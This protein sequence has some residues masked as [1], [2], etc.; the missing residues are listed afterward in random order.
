MVFKI[1]KMKFLIIILLVTTT[2]TRVAAQYDFDNQHVI[3]TNNANV[4]IGTNDPWTKLQL[5]GTLGLGKFS[6]SQHA[7]L[8]IDY[9]D[10]NGG[11]GTTT[12]K[13]Q[14]WGGGF[15]FRRNDAAGERNQFFF[16][17]ASSHYMDIYDNNNNVAVRFNSGGH[18]FFNGNVGIGT[19][20]PGDKLEISGRLRVST[21]TSD[22]GLSYHT[23]D[24]PE[25]GYNAVWPDQFERA[26]IFKS[27]AYMDGYGAGGGG[28][29]F[30]TYDKNDG[31]TWGSFSG[32][33]KQAMVIRRN[34]N[35]GVGTA[36]PDA[37]L[38]VKGDIHTRE[39]RVDMTGA[40]GPDYVFEKN[41]SLLPLSQLESY[42]NQNKHLPEVSSAKEMEENGLNLK[43]MNLILLKKVEE[44][45]LHLIEMKKANEAQILKLESEIAEIKNKR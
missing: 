22:Y 3:Y 24:Q 13:H 32:G 9:D 45:T 5:V 39:V 20:T 14:R 35:I 29:Q 31:G 28:F 43:E 16:G 40:V 17:G 30:W 41:Y 34:G 10:G 21:N 37:K 6:S 33:L 42:I 19:Q 23:S 36:L 12:F 2:A 11:S 27:N 1:I 15:F 26:W 38:T 44:L 8:L 25:T 7:G 18:S 4:G